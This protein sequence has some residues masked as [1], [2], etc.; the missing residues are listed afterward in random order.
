M[1]YILIDKDIVQ[2]M[3]AFGAALV[4]VQPGKLKASGESTF[5]GKKVGV[6]GDEK[7]VEVPGCPYISGAYTVPGTGTLK[8]A[9]L[10]S[11]Q[12]AQHTQTGGKKMLLKGSSFKAKFEVQTPAQIP[13]P[14]STPDPMTQYTGG[15]GMFITTNGTYKGT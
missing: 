8:I 12:I 2:F 11:D 14:S 5:K 10:N 15:T 6:E 13:P 4:V 7:E 9:G 3:P 1:D